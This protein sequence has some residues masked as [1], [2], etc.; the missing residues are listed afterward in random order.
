[1]DLED[2]SNYIALSLR[3]LQPKEEELGLLGKTRSSSGT[4][5]T[6]PSNAGFNYEMVEVVDA[7]YD[8]SINGLG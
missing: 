7:S 8:I 5:L 4:I 1:L 2:E 6:S 3:C